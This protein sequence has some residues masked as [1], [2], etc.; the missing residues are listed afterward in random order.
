VPTLEEYL[1]GVFASLT[2]ARMMAD[3]Q[4]VSAAETYARH[5]LLRHF[6]VPHLRFGDVELTIPVA[7]ESVGPVPA[8]GGLDAATRKQLRAAIFE[9]VARLLGLPALPDPAVALI[10]PAVD[11]RMDRLA[12][13]DAAQPLQTR[14][15]SFARELAGDLIKL[16]AQ[17]DLPVRRRLEREAL[18]QALNDLAA[19]LFKEAPPAPGLGGLQVIAES[20][21]LREQRPSDVIVIKMSIR[22]EGM[23]WQTMEMSD[24]RT[25]RKLLP[26]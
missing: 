13:G 9:T 26:E 8:P 2:Q 10:G 1:G 17:L 6:A 23:E 5:D 12:A 4:A 16:L 20:H 25:E 19:K 3:A 22:E 18:E 14:L 11:A 24:G 7:I 15:A 21:R